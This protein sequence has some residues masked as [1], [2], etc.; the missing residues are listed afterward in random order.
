MGA[1]LVI[2]YCMDFIYDNGFHIPQ[3]CAAALGLEQDVKRLRRG[4][5]NMRRPLE[6]RTPLGH[7]R[8][9]G[10]NRS[11]NLRHEQPAL[12]GHLE[13]LP[14][15]PFKV[16]VDIVAESLERRDVED[17]GAVLE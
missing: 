10:T 13:N 2:S 7:E 3:N 8:V 14:Q 12:A 6:H 16:L 5:E 1:A 9:A 15:R 11:A 17:F 4:H